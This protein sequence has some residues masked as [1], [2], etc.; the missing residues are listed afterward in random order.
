MLGNHDTA[1]IW[2][3][4]D[5]WLEEGIS[6]RQAEY[7]AKRLSIP[8]TERTSWIERLS[9][10]TGALVQAKFADLF[11]GPA[12]NIMVYFTDLLGS[13][14]TYNKPGTVSDENWTLRIPS[15]YEKS[16]QEK[17]PD[18]LALNIPKALSMALRARR[19]PTSPEI[20]DLIRA[21]Q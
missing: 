11:V 3:V 2:Q 18:N 16:Y 19:G 1:S 7:L 10:D 21:L 13:K 20:N 15:N 5:R 17:L 14:E 6:R 4:A 8:E 12:Q 9:V